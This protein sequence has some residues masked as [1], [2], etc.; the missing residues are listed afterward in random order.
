[1]ADESL[2]NDNSSP[3]SGNI[4]VTTT[5]SSGLVVNIGPTGANQEGINKTNVE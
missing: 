2:H 3:T 1:M 4:N 5:D